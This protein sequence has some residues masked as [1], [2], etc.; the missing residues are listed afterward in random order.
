[1]RKQKY[2]MVIRRTADAWRRVRERRVFEL[3]N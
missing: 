1:M 2:G 3:L